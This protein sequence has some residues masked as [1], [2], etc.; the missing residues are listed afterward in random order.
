MV[1][2]SPA[3]EAKQI[4][5]L[6]AKFTAIGRLFQPYRPHGLCQEKC[7]KNFA[8]ILKHH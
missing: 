2:A 3:I 8:S 4:Q 7:D 5:H 6:A 1:R